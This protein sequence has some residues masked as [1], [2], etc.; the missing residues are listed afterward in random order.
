MASHLASSAS[1][2]GESISGCALRSA[3]LVA[4]AILTTLA[5]AGLTPTNSHILPGT[6]REPLSHASAETDAACVPPGQAPEHKGSRSGEYSP[7]LA[8]EDRE[9]PRH[10]GGEEFCQDT[11]LVGVVGVELGDDQPGETGARDERRQTREGLA[12]REA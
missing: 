8:S 11:F 4:L 6:P 10:L 3:I 12:E 5:L 1:L 7:P 2:H 9:R